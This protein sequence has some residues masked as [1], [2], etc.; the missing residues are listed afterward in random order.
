MYTYT[1]GWEI[2]AALKFQCLTSYSLFSF[3]K[4]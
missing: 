3:E 1:V 2:I 4:Q